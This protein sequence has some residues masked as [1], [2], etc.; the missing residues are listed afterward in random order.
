MIDL[1]YHIASIVAVFL[2]L[3]LGVLIGSTIV[4]DDLLVDQQQKMIERLEEQFYGLKD[5]EVELLA[6]NDY[7]EQLISNYEN[8]SQALLPAVV[9]GRL[10]QYKVAVIVTGDSEIPA[11]MINAIS[12]AGA[13]VVSKTV[14]LSNMKLEDEETSSRIKAYYGLS[15]SESKA[16]VRQNIADSVAQVILNKGEEGT[17]A[18][19]QQNNLVKFS[20]ANDIPL[21]GIII[22]GGAN[23]F[24]NCFVDDFD[25][26]LISNF[27]HADAKVFGVEGVLVDYSYIGI[28]QEY[29]ISTIDNIDK[30]PGQVSLILAMEGEAGN[31]GIKA[32]AQKFMPTIP[33]DYK[34]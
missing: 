3:G 16:A 29:N 28:F 2:A 7:K 20:G 22:V 30:S 24:S 32:T 10:E 13:Q 8:Y 18:F 17:I 5:R 15:N 1:K 21:D 27:L 14:L 19:L 34:L 23:N 33:V 9:S 25:S 6:D 11:G 12:M 26:R 4:G 31:Y